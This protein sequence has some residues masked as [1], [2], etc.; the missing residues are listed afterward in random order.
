MS[1]NIRNTYYR[2]KPAIPRRWQIHLRRC[3][4]KARK[5]KALANWPI[6]PAAAN[7]PAEWPGWPDGKQFAVVL[8]HDV[9]S[10][11][12]QEQV[13]PL[14]ELEIELGYRS[15][16]NFVP[17]RY[18]LDNGL[19]LV[20]GSKGF[21]VGVHGLYH[22]G[23][24]YQSFDVFRQR[25][26]QINRY[27][28]EWE[29]VGFRSPAMHHNLE[30]IHL[31][32]IEY[33]MSTFDTDPFEPQGDGVGT[34]FPFWVQNPQQLSGYVELPYTLPQDFTLFILM[35]ETAIRI[36]KRKLDWVARNGG[37]VLL[38]TH[39]DYMYFSQQSP[40]FDQFP[41]QHYADLLNYIRTR[42]SG[43][44]WAALPREVATYVRQHLAQ[45]PKAASNSPIRKTDH[46]FIEE[47]G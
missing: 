40:T 32:N 36:W 46:E 11:F 25:A 22:D 33:D 12:G 18:P 17:E 27:L 20:L 13:K 41:V 35:Q 45:K 38:N 21:E 37:M 8:T 26:G 31:L 42:Y 6:M 3:M 19:R 9:E 28:K 39:P 44:Y 43:Q 47:Q 5:A 1:A 29:A 2:L 4:I 34:I 16:F 15:A 14:M 30:W 24:L 7:P 10:S 23:L